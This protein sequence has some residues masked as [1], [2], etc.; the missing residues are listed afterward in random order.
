MIR[1]VFAIPLIAHGLAHISG[2][3]AS[4][5]P[6]SAGYPIDRPWLLS[7]DIT[8][9]SP[10]GKAFGLLWLVA[11]LGLAGSG[12]GL[13][14]RQEWWPNLATMAAVISLVVIVPWWRT[15]PTGAW[16]GAA[17]D[18]LVIILLTTPLKARILDLVG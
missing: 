14:F 18:M 15:V 2:F 12:L 7:A 13:I 10:V 11:A 1:F 8:L 4:W 5:T 17:F 3:I 16:V 6:A 9:T